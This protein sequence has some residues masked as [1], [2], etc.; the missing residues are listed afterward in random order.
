MS[1]LPKWQLP[2]HTGKRY[3]KFSLKIQVS[4]HSY[5]STGKFQRD[6]PSE[7]HVFKTGFITIS[8]NFTEKENVGQNKKTEEYV[9]NET[10]RKNSNATEISYLPD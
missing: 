10:I 7:R 5:L 6:A 2:A 3:S 9:S 4:H 1:N 8:H